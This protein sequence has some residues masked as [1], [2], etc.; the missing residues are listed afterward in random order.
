MLL[1]NEDDGDNAAADDGNVDSNSYDDNDVTLD[2][3]S[4]DNI[5]YI[6]DD[7]TCGVDNDSE[8]NDSYDDDNNDDDDNYDV[9][10]DS[11]DYDDDDG[12]ILRLK[13][14]TSRK[15]TLWFCHLSLVIA[16]FYKDCRD[17]VIRLQTPTLRTYR[18]NDL[19]QKDPCTETTFTLDLKT[20]VGIILKQIRA[21]SN[22]SPIKSANN[23]DV[24]ENVH[25]Q[26]ARYLYILQP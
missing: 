4:N 17:V 26:S 7:D 24:Y 8:D 1:I 16:M 2:G 13:L 9:D 10:G 15:C 22:W 6:N 18:K 23:E 12:Y 5:N 3:N 25:T 21:A 20:V 11:N 19:R 14:E